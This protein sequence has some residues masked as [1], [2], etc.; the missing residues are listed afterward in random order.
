M[1]VAAIDPGTTQS[2]WVSWDGTSILYKEILPNS[3]LMDR[4]RELTDPRREPSNPVFT[5]V[6]IEMIRSYGMP[7]GVEVFETVRLIGR[8]EEIC[9][10]NRQCCRLVYRQEEKMHHC[11][12]PK[13][14]DA[15][16][17]QALIDR[18]GAPGTKAKKG[19]TYG[20]KADLWQAFGI[21]VL[22]WDHLTGGE[23]TIKDNR[24]FTKSELAAIPTT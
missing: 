9:A 6:V 18:F 5:L 16:I 8:L 7:V 19:L 15:S 2:A 14:N 22:G 1:I 4:L 12:S 11:H 10:R 24:V 13:A 3:D 20:L 21:A 23:W 17:R